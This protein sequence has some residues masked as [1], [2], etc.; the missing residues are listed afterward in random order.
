[1]VVTHLYIINKYHA[2]NYYI[3]STA[4]LVVVSNWLRQDLSTGLHCLVTQF[5]IGSS[6][7]SSF[8]LAQLSSIPLVD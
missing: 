8:L 3:C 4:V 2:Y 7:V 6:V 5:D 1:M